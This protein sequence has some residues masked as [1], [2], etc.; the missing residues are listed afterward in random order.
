MLSKKKQ[1]YYKEFFHRQSNDKIQIYLVIK[2]HKFNENRK[3]S[4]YYLKAF[5]RK[6]IEFGD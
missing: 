3:S 5:E 6:A 4:I 2:F 1:G